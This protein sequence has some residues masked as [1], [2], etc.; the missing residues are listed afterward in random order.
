MEKA[1]NWKIL[2]ALFFAP[3]SLLAHGGHGVPEGNSLIHYLLSPMH[4]IPMAIIIAGAVLYFR[5]KR[6]VAQKK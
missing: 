5:W 2:V 3:V 4:A 1:V 6:A